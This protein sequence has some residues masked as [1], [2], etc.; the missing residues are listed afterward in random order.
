MKRSLAGLRPPPL[1]IALFS[2]FILT[3]SSPVAAEPCAELRSIYQQSAERLRE[4]HQL[5]L[6]RGCLDGRGEDCQNM[7][8][9][10]RELQSATLML[11]QRLEQLECSLEGPTRSATPCERIAR[12]AAKSEESLNDT[13]R[14]YERR[15]R[16]ARRRG[17][18]CRALAATLEQRRR[19]WRATQARER[20]LE[21]QGAAEEAPEGAEE[22]RAATEGA[23][24]TSSDDEL[25]ALLRRHLSEAEIESFGLRPPPTPERNPAPEEG[26]PAQ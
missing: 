26:A 7:V 9:A 13:Q 21:C 15:C 4:N 17:R 25:E 8:S 20:E 16:G 6:R 12:L 24:P 11:V 3:L 22:A 5:L 14:N 10:F 1:R 2:L 19:V 18:R 23:N